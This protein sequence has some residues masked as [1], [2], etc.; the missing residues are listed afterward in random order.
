MTTRRSVGLATSVKPQPPKTRSLP[1][2]LITDLGPVA[3]G[4]RERA[5][6]ATHRSRGGVPAEQ[7]A[8]GILVDRLP[9]GH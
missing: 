6:T 7:G 9:M 8:P 2:Y 1:R 4:Y 5:L 3:T